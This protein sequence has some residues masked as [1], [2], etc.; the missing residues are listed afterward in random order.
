M[1]G[2]GCSAGCL[3]MIGMLFAAAGVDLLL[4]ASFGAALMAFVMG[5]MPMYLAWNLLQDAKRAVAERTEASQ[6][7]I[8]RSILRLA[9]S[10][11]GRV[12]PAMV[13]M[14]VQGVTVKEAKRILDEMTRQN[15]CGMDSD[16]RGHVFYCFTAERM[17]GQEQTDEE[18]SAEQWVERMTGSDQ[19]TRR[20]GLD[21]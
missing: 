4:E 16:A 13:A 10:R 8:E 12:T 2:R 11:D 6:A 15:L 7:R 5:G 17:T 19:Q 18:L 21:E 14:D 9:Q 3:V 20:Q 1:D